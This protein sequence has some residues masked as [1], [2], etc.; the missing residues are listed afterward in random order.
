[1]HTVLE[2]LRLASADGF[3]YIADTTCSKVP[4][5]ELLSKEYA[6][7]R[8]KLLNADRWETMQLS[9][10]VLCRVLVNGLFSCIIKWCVVN[11]VSL[12]QFTG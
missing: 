2:A 9:V 11:H 1:M 7:Q 10:T 8:R 3:A 12:I 5:K 4:V 6:A